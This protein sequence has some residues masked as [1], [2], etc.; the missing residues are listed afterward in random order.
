M[1]K[2]A[3]FDII[4]K[5]KEVEHTIAQELFN[6]SR[7]V[8]DGNFHI[9]L[10][11]CSVKQLNLI[12][13]IPTCCKISLEGQFPPLHIKVMGV[14]KQDNI[15]CFASYRDP[16]PSQTSSD[17]QFYNVRSQPIRISGEKGPKPTVK[18]FNTSYV[19]LTFLSS[20]STTIELRPQFI[21][22]S[23]AQTVKYVTSKD[24]QKFDNSNTGVDAPT[25]PPQPKMIEDFK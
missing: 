16:E 7:V 19:Y 4:G 1:E 21:D 22:P 25:V 10:E 23:K 18:V 11:N 9:L 2:N 17:M 3:N 13:N 15:S 20:R 14:Q 8:D 12:Y 5:L 6:I 24:Q